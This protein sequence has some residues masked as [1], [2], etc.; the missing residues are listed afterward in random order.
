MNNKLQ[1]PF[2]LIVSTTEE[3]LVNIINQSNLPAYCLKIILE[4]IYNKLEQLDKEEIEK[5]N[6]SI[7]NKSTKK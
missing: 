4:R 2:S 6:E 7:K 5:Y 1:K 3:N